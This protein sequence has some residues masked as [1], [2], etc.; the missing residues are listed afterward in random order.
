MKLTGI[1]LVVVGIL[2]LA[3]QG[4]S[5]NQTEK[6]AQLGPIQIQHTETHT[7]PIPPLIG[8]GLVLVGAVVLAAGARSK[9]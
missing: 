1:A 8:G 5:Y 4:F 6:D 2:A 9:F 7:V 3:Y